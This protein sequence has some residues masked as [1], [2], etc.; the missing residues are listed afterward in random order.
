MVDFGRGQ[1]LAIVKADDVVHKGK[2]GL[3][4]EDVA[5]LIDLEDVKTKLVE[6]LANIV[7]YTTTAVGGPVLRWV[8]GSDD[9]SAVVT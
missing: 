6:V 1:M 4:G 9:A 3:S 8:K 7:N 2:K 5:Y